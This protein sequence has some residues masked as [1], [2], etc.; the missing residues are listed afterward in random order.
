MKTSTYGIGLDWKTGDYY[1]VV[2]GQRVARTFASNA[3]ALGYVD[4]LKDAA[5]A[6]SVYTR[7]I[8]QSPHTAQSGSLTRFWET[9][10]SAH[11]PGPWIVGEHGR[12]VAPSE[13]RSEDYE[14]AT[15]RRSDHARLIAAAP[16]LLEA[17]EGFLRLLPS[18]EGLGGHAP[19]V[20]FTT[21]AH[22]AR[23]AIRAAKSEA[24]FDEGGEA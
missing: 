18:E 4:A 5:W 10:M 12:I 21:H 2:N 3:Q 22:K 7:P 9:E 8:Q 6:A 16:A 19:I 24:G 13:G 11:T 17:L 15:V 20:A 23:A 14:I 1:V